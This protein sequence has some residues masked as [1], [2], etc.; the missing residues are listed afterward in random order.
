MGLP[1]AAP[2]LEGDCTV[3]MLR[4]TDSAY[5]AEHRLCLLDE[6]TRR[7]SAMR[8]ELVREAM[9]LCSGDGVM[10]NDMV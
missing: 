9:G 4:A 2:E 3:L 10:H 8:A 1:S 7:I 6:I 5:P